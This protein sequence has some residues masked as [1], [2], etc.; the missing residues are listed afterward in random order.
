M[1]V[2]GK[3]PSEVR[4]ILAAADV[5]VV[6]NSAR[7]VASSTYTSPMKLFEA[8]GSGAEVVVS[9]VPAIREIAGSGAVWYFAP[10]DPASL[11]KAVKAALAG[12]ARVRMSAYTWDERAAAILASL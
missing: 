10:D 1:L 8:L 11:A 2:T 9:D 4:E 5:V 12:P 6:P 7:V 3:T